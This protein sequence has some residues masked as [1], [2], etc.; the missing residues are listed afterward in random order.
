MAG[1]RM[2]LL[3]DKPTDRVTIRD[4]QMV[5]RCAAFPRRCHDSGTQG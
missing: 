3:G 4:L 5:R 1:E 2:K